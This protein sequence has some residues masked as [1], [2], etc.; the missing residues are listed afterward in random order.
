MLDKKVN[1]K[2][3]WYFNPKGMHDLSG[4]RKGWTAGI[5]EG[6]VGDDLVGLFDYFISL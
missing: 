3:V 5:A 6:S 1:V 4:D 2:P